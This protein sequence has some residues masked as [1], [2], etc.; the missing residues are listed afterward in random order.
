MQP[1][2]SA[3]RAIQAIVD[4]QSEAWNRNDAAAWAR[5]FTEDATFIYVRGDLTTGRDAVEKLH[6]FIFS[7][8][9]KATHYTATLDAVQQLAPSLALASVSTEVTNFSF[10]PPGVAPT[11]P[12]VLRTR[13]S[14]VL[15]E[16][17]Q[18][19]KILLAQNTAVAPQPMKP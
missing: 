17:E 2:E 13:F 18:G 16:R 12:G 10:L 5:D 9:Y 14:F 8:P 11:A 6:A 4:A 15:V 7:G 3:E 1:A 19:W